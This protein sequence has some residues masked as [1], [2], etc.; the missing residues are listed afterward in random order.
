MTKRIVLC[1]DD[2]G[3]APAVSDGI[4]ALVQKERLSAVSCLVTPPFW[5]AAAVALGSVA[6]QIDTGLHFNLTQGEALSTAYRE[7]YGDHFMSLGTLM[8]RSMLRQLNQQVILAECEAQLQAFQ[9]KMGHLPHFIDGHQHVHQFPVIREAFLSIYEQHL[10]SHG[11]YVRL[12]KPLVKSYKDI[13]H[14]VILLSGALAFERQLKNRAIPHN[15]SFAGAYSFKDSADYKAHF[16]QALDDVKE[17]GLIMCH[18][19]FAG[20]DRSDPIAASRYD[21]YLYLE[22]DQFL[23]DC[24]QKGIKMARFGA[25]DPL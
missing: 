21:E 16:N 19:G 2:Y 14:L 17:G 9:A 10:R 5:G 3:Q 1:A 18:P 15:T 20:V 4:L 13:K 22:S 11:A 25:S 6:G 23:Q 12:S 8:A 7:T 24:A